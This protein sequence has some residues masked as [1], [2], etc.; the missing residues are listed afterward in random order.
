MRERLTGIVVKY[1]EPNKDELNASGI[2]PDNTSLDEALEEISEKMEEADKLHDQTTQEKAKKCS[3]R[4]S[5]SPRNEAAY[6][7]DPETKKRKFEEPKSE[8]KKKS[9]SSGLEALVYLRE[10]AEKDQKLKLNEM[11]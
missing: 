4:C 8:T 6:I 7:R 3:L 11:L 10:K 9:R 5:E 1:K 2:S